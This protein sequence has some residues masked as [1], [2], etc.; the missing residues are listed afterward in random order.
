MESVTITKGLLLSRRLRS[1]QQR[2]TVDNP[3]FWWR[4]VGQKRNHVPLI[5]KGKK[6]STTILNTYRKVLITSGEKKCEDGRVPKEDSNFLLLLLWKAEALVMLGRTNEGSLNRRPH[7]VATSL[8]DAFFPVLSQ[9]PV[10]M[11]RRRT[12]MGEGELGEWGRNLT[13]LIGPT[14][15]T[16]APVLCACERG[17]A[18]PWWLLVLLFP[19]LFYF[20]K[21][22]RVFKKSKN[23]F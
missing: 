1:S 17:R 4:D 16:C 15:F 22:V 10:A 5:K 7:V 8:S 2:L 12:T 6:I 21:L 23:V 20:K 3:L 14:L 13:L 11:I 18:R 19:Y 9:P